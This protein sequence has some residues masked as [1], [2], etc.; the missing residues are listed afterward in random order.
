MR[1]HPEHID[2][3]DEILVSEKLL[4]ADDDEVVPLETVDALDEVDDEVEK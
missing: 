1:E 2:V 3:I 4:L